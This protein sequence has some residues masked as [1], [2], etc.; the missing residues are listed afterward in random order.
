MPDEKKDQPRRA[1]CNTCR[2]WE[3]EPAPEGMHETGQCRRF[4]PKAT[5]YVAPSDADHD[6][7]YP[8]FGF[9]ETYWFV[10]CGEHKAAR[11]PHIE[12]KRLAVLEASI[13]PG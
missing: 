11:K 5:F 8:E 4:P 10:W 2:F 7:C 1:V 9:P 6:A 3:L 13:G 12:A